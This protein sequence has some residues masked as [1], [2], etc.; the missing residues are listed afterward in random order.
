MSI[1]SNFDE[2][3]RAFQAL[4]MGCAPWT[5]HPYECPCLRYHAAVLEQYHAD[6]I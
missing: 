5:T 4:Q 1:F 2:V 6:L 3:R